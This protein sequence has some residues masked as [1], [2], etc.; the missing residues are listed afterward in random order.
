VLPAT[1]RS[2]KK[3]AARIQVMI[4]PMLPIWSAKLCTSAFSVTVFVS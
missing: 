2:V 4:L 1:R 3:T